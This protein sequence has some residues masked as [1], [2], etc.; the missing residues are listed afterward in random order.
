M[1]SEETLRSYRNEIIERCISLELLMS[2]IISYHYF[3]KISMS[4]L[5]E[6]LYD[7]NCSFGFKRKIVEKI[8]P[9]LDRSRINNLNRIGSIRNYFAHYHP[10]IIHPETGDKVAVDTRHLYRIIDFETLYKEFQRLYPPVSEYLTG[11]LEKISGTHLRGISD[12]LNDPEVR[13]RLPPGLNKEKGG[14][15]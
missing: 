11:I 7:E 9:N 13:P 2:G 1:M 4:F 15:D 12:L 6:V 10:N 5:L 3:G 8:V 14:V